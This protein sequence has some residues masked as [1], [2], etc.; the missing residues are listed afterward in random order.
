MTRAIRTASILHNESDYPGHAGERVK[1]NLVW[2]GS[3]Y[4]WYTG[5]GE[6]TEVSGKTVANACHGARESWGRSH[7]WDFRASWA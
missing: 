6:D 3:T 1:L 2:D 5:S 7:V 4:R